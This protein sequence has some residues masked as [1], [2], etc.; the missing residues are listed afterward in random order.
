[1]KG[2]RQIYAPPR[3][4]YSQRAGQYCKCC[5][6]HDLE[7]ILELG[8]FEMLHHIHVPMIFLLV[9]YL[10]YSFT[11]TAGGT[12]RGRGRGRGRGFGYSSSRGMPYRGGFRGRRGNFRGY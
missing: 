7:M 2:E 11:L 3:D 12:F 8:L 4:K 5:L 6:G 10:F 9:T 1:M